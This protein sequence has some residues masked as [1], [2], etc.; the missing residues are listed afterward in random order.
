MNITFMPRAGR[1]ALASW[2]ALGAP[3]GR[4]KALWRCLSG[5]LLASLLWV[6]AAR[7]QAYDWSIGAYAG[8]Y[9]DTEPAGW[10]Q[11]NAGY[12]DHYMVALTGSKTLW[13]SENWKLALQVS[14]KSPNCGCVAG[15]W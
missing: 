12:L 3:F 13:R 15:P 4:V 2:P 8:Q 11:G 10:T 6:P 14:R 9:Y 7:A 1:T 5:V